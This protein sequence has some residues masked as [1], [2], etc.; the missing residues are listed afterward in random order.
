MVRQFIIYDL[1]EQ[2]LKWVVSLGKRKKKVYKSPILRNLL[3]P[4]QCEKFPLDRGIE[5]SS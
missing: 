3:L 4:F 2:F 5:V 1:E